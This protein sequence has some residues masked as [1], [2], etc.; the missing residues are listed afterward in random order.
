MT[1][2]YAKYA[3]GYFRIATVQDECVIVTDRDKVAEYLRAPDDVLSMQDAAN[4][5]QQL[6]FTMGYGVAHRT[7]HT[8][9]VR[10][11]LTQSIKTHLEAMQAEIQS[12]LDDLI[13]Y[14]TEWTPFTIYRLMAMVVARTSNRVTVSDGLHKDPVFL[15]TA[16]DYAEA[17]VLSAE[18]VRP[19]PNWMKHIVIRLT[20]VWSCRRRATKFLEPILTKRL[21][22]DFDQGKKPE[23][24]LQW[25]MDAAPPI[26]RNIPHM[27]E[28]I[29]SMNV[30]SIHTTTMT[31]T[32]ALFKLAAEPE[33]YTPELRQELE[34]V[35]KEGPLTKD[36]LTQLRKMDSFLR[37]SARLNNSGLPRPIP[38]TFTSFKTNIGPLILVAIQRNAKKTFTFSDGTVIPAGAKIG[39]PTRFAHRDPKIYKN[40]EE[41]D[42]FRFARIRDGTTDNTVS[43]S[44]QAISTAPE[45]HVFGHGKHAW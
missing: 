25:L 16:I 45:L 19:F 39:S 3:P 6:A 40:P 5:Q 23:D 14:P 42:G 37:E 38:I 21:K 8:P 22:G 12:S 15:N 13:G 32:G 18:L 43:A 44:Y 2:G 29:M 35:L 34:Q 28:R 11:K 1:E 41:F 27:V 24:L 36:R 26:E 30:A 9:I 4:D 20:P 7:Y 31:F 10:T 33:K 17:V